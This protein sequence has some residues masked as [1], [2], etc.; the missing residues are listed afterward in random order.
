[1]TFSFF[2]DNVVG[3][4]PKPKVSAL[5][6]VFEE[7]TVCDRMFR[8]L[9]PVQSCATLRLCMAEVSGNPRPKQ[10]SGAKEADTMLVVYRK[11]AE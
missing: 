1:M 7:G 4:C 2:S 8:D 6:V 9:S 11:K 10:F 5:A 3:C